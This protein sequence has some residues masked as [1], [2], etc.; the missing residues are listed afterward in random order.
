MKNK[1]LFL[2]IILVGFLSSCCYHEKSPDESYK[3]VTR[4]K[5]DSLFWAKRSELIES[6][7]ELGECR[8]GTLKAMEDCANRTKIELPAST[9]QWPCHKNK[10]AQIKFQ[11]TLN[12]KEIK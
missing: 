6:Y 1:T 12:V 3:F 10:S 11:V 8:A 4:K 9:C 5:Y 2:F 7:K